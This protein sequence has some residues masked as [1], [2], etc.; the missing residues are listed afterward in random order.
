MITDNAGTAAPKHELTHVSDWRW[1]EDLREC[2]ANC[3]ETA[4][5]RLAIGGR[6]TPRRQLS[7]CVF[8][9][10]QNAVRGELAS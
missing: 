5:Q 10:Q 6:Q 9:Q 8:G 2:A 3:V 1:Y 7:A 4:R